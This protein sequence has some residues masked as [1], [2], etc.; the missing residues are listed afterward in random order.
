MLPL[1]LHIH[2]TNVYWALPTCQLDAESTTVNKMAIVSAVVGLKSPPVQRDKQA[3]GIQYEE[4]SDRGGHPSTQP[5]LLGSTQNTA[6][7]SEKEISRST[8]KAPGSRQNLI[9]KWH[10]MNGPESWLRPGAD[11]RVALCF[12]DYKWDLLVNYSLKL[13]HFSRITW[14][15][16]H[17][18]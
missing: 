8:S 4:G 7:C 18:I 13:L 14:G 11:Y 17:F 10:I 5:R 9:N 15:P 6:S 12:V 2:S 3:L 1:L 16:Q